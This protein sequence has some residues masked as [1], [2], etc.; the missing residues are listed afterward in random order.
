MIILRLIFWGVALLFST[1]AAPFHVSTCSAKG[2]SFSTSQ[3]LTFRDFD[4]SRPSGC[5][6][7]SLAPLS[8]DVSYAYWPFLYIW[9]T[10]SFFFYPFFNW[11]DFFV[12]DFSEFSIFLDTNPSLDT[13]FADIFSH[14]L[15]CFFTL[16]IVSFAV[17]NFDK[18]PVCVTSAFSV[19]FRKSL[20]YPVSP[21]FS[22]E[23]S[24]CWCCGSCPHTAG[25][26]SVWQGCPPSG[27]T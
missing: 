12:V 25:K 9:R 27:R 4:H 24:P 6:M 3:T 13:W 1:A 18:S 5:E 22:V 17:F 16:L 8:G 23:A 2:S 26:Q 7:V 11:V 10:V 20:P 21:S 14:S 15:G 19:T